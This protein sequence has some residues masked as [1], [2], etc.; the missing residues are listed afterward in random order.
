MTDL[1]TSISW[2]EPLLFEPVPVD[3]VEMADQ[4][5][6]LKGR[7]EG[8]Y[9]AETR[10]RIGRLLQLTNS[11]YSNLIEGQYTEPKVIEQKA[12]IKR[13]AKQLTE[14][15][16]SHVHVQRAFERIIDRDGGADWADLFAVNFVSLIH[17][18]LFRDASEQELHIDGLKAPMVP[19]QLR[20]MAGLNVSV[21]QHEAPAYQAV[22]PML[23][24]MQVVYGRLADPRYRLIAT[25]AYHHRLAWVYPFPD[26]N[27]RVVRMVTHL[28]LLKL[29]LASPL[30]SLS[31]GL[32]RE[33]EAYYQH[34]A[35]ADQHRQGDLDGRGQLSLKA[36]QAFV[37]FMLRTCI[38]QMSYMLEALDRDALRARLERAVAFDER[39]MAAEI[40]PETARALHIL[41]TQGAVARND[42]K[43]FMG[44]GERTA[45]NQLKKLVQLGV[46]DSPS[47]KSRLIYPGFPVWFAQ[48][49][50]PDLHRRF[51]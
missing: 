43:V 41:I 14:I 16:T 29:G 17:R 36:L 23:E 2:L 51:I 1:Y 12:Q 35:Q 6:T 18:G 11:F 22:R 33:H 25:L 47:P 40:K 24:R 9:P 10:E 26:G 8:L 38:D 31:R 13:T 49:V 20:D 32:A 21:G 46:V 3:M 27:G 19:G 5:L 48:L 28:Q 15:A 45:I 4:M 44:L 7:L 34:L 50:F 42:F 30:W 37:R 39:F